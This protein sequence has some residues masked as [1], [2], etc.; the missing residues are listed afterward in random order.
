MPGYAPIQ[1]KQA[2]LTL[3]PRKTT[4]PNPMTQHLHHRPRRLR[5]TEALRNLVAEHALSASD[6]IYPVFVLPGKQR[7]ESI[8]SMPGVERLSLDLL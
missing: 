4:Q 1:L 7:H 5:R 2:A 3:Q 8:A 6:L